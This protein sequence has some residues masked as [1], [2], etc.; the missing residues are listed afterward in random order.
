MSQV[1]CIANA[2]DRIQ[3]NI[4]N[5]VNGCI[6]SNVYYKVGYMDSSVTEG[7]R[8]WDSISGQYP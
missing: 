3:Y 8:D 4:Y 2:T 5:D 1:S 7:H 6:S